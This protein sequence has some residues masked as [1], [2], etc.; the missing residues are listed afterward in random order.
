MKHVDITSR[1]T[2]M[3][4]VHMFLVLMFSLM[5]VMY[6]CVGIAF[7]AMLGYVNT[8]CLNCVILAGVRVSVLARHHS[9]I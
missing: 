1:L 7:H 8:E 4:N 3:C 2:A 5:T 6:S 9:S